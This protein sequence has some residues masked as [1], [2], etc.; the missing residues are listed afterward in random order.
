MVLLPHVA[1]AGVQE[2]G[3]PGRSRCLIHIAISGWWSLAGCLAKP[4][5]QELLFFSTWAYPYGC[6]SFLLLWHLVTKS[7]PSR[8]TQHA[9]T[10]QAATFTLCLPILYRVHMAK[11]RVIVGK[12]ET[13]LN[14]ESHGL[15]RITIITGFMKTKET[16]ITQVLENNGNFSSSLTS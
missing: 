1:M 15:L 12:A 7:T 4:I 10:Y 5:I 11:S 8:P 2:V 14:A 9:S 6:L 16:H 13:D 3:V